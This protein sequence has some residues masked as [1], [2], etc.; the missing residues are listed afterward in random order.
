MDAA[1]IFDSIGKLVTVLAAVTGSWW[2]LE[3][4][5]KRDEHFPRVYFEVSVNFIGTQKGQFVAELVATLENKGVVPLKIKHF[6]F[7]LL[8][9]KDTDSLVKGGHEIREQLA[10]P[11][12]IQEGV[13]V[14][15][16]WDYSFIY[17]GIKTEYNFIT[18][19]SSQYSFVR[20]QGDFEYLSD[21]DSHHAAKVF[22]VPAQS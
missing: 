13:F 19:I 8:G 18:L 4:W 2:A 16:D 7:K 17:P 1:S 22:K 14:P 6:S 3:K 5:R 10:F 20:L 11:H 9:L 15:S 21:G 12:A